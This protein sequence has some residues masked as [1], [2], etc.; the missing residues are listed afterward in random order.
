MA[1]ILF[2]CFLPTTPVFDQFCWLFQRFFSDLPHLSWAP[3]G[4]SP[5]K[6]HDL[7]EDRSAKADQGANDG[8]HRT[9]QQKALLFGIRFS[10]VLVG[11]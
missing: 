7:G 3:R 11:G 8:Q 1:V 4:T 10:H 9:L 5:T 6:R 2:P